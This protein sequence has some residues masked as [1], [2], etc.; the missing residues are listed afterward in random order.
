MQFEVNTK[1]ALNTPPEVFPVTVTLE[2]EF[3]ASFKNEFVVYLYPRE[4]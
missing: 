4:Q 2:D 3:G 1:V